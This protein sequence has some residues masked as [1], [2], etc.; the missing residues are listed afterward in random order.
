VNPQFILSHPDITAGFVRQAGLGLRRAGWKCDAITLMVDRPDALWRKSIC[1]IGKRFSLDLDRE[2]RRR[3][4]VDPPWNSVDTSPVWELLRVACLRAQLDRR[5]PDIIFERA[6]NSLERRTI[7]ALSQSITHVF[8]YEFSARATFEAAAKRGIGRIYE[9]PSPEY[10]Y[11]EELLAAEM[12][13]I[14]ELSGPGDAYFARKRVERLARRQREWALADLVIVNSRFT[15][16][17]FSRAGYDTS[18]VRVISLGA[19]VV[20]VKD[21]RSGPADTRWPMK[22]L[23]AGTFSVRKGAHYLLEAWKQLPRGHRLELD[24]YGAWALPDRFRNDLPGSVK[25]CGSI[26]QSEL[27]HRYREADVLVFPTLCDGFGLVVTEAFAQ[28]LP[29]ITTDRAGAA[30]LVRR[31]ENG[32]I[33]PA[34]DAAALASALDWCQGNRPALKAMRGAALETARR[35][36]WSAYSDELALAVADAFGLSMARQ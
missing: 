5:I 32:L 34:G 35:R 9:V 13:M 30:D 2:F 1:A 36:P 20:G 26:P 25:F 24:I 29:V 16:D 4:L 19:P 27:F 21:T 28:G 3:S 22:C 12:A 31:H 15:L 7:R 10:N 11:V 18:K 6:I 23:W 14:P 17:T 8:G 33:V